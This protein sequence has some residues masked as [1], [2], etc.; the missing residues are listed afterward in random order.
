MTDI[1]EMTNDSTTLNLK[2]KTIENYGS[3]IIDIKSE[4]DAAFIVELTKENGDLVRQKIIDSPQKVNF[5][6]LPP[7]NYILKTLVDENRNGK[8][9]TGDFL[10]KKQPEKIKFFDKI[11]EVKANWDVNE[12]FVID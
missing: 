12:T 10:L 6:L 11:I 8:W 9:D 2:T 4:L 7:G 5:K 3:R 1:Y